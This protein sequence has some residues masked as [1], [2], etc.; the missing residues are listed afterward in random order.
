MTAGQTVKFTSIGNF[1]RVLEA[2]DAITILTY[3]NGQI[4]T[5]SERVFGGF[6]EKFD[7]QFQQVEV[8]SATAQTVQLVIRLGS[9]VSYDVSP[10]GNVNVTNP[11]ALDAATLAA[12]ETVNVGN[13]GGAFSQGRANVTNAN[14]VLIAANANRRYLMLQNNDAA[15]VLRV[16][17]DGSAATAAQGFRVQPGGALEIPAYAVTGAINCM[18]ET[19]TAASGNVEFVEG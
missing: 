16:K 9:I 1:L 14:Q 7:E 6:A 3:K 13:N 15:A 8:Y 10:T 17:L 19:A 11:V 18:M 2:K 4:Y 5:E 12:L